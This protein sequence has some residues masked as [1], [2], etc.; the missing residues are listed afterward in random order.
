MAANWFPTFTGL[1]EPD[2]VVR[3]QR[4][5][6]WGLGDGGRLP[7]LMSPKFGE[8]ASLCYV[9]GAA[10]ALCFLVTLDTIAPLRFVLL[11]LLFSGLTFR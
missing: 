8:I 2:G 9:T 7:R 1:M 5:G 10:A 11:S 3:R 6:G 4:R